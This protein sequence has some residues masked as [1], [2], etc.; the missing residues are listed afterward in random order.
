[1]QTEFFGSKLGNEILLEPSHCPQCN[2]DFRP[3]KGNTNDVIGIF[4]LRTGI[5]IAWKCP[6]CRYEWGR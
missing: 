4:G 3:V 1:M 5:V 2:Y 6:H